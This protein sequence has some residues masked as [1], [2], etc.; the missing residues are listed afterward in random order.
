MAALKRNLHLEEGLHFLSAYESIWN[1]FST[2]ISF[3]LYTIGVTQHQLDNDMLQLYELL[4]KFYK[5]I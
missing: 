4:K 2:T 5:D 3:S 1:G